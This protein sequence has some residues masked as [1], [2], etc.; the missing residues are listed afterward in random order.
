MILPDFTHAEWAL[1]GVASIFCGV[2]KAGLAGL[3]MLN[4]LIMAHL[5]PGQAS[6]GVVLPMLIAADVLAV[7]VFG[8]KHADW[9]AIGRLIVPMLI[10]IVAGWGLMPFIP[11]GAFGSVIGWM[12]LAMVS[13]QLVR[14]VWPHFDQHL[15]HSRLFGWIVGIISGL[16]TMIANAAGP[17]SV[18][19]FLILGFAKR[20]FIAT[21][22]WLFLIINVLK[23]PLSAQ[24]GLI[25]GSSL[26]LNVVLAPFVGAGFFLGRVMTNKLPQRPFER[27]VLLLTII[28]AVRLIVG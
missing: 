2:G 1:A 7:T 25:N 20:E 5:V 26:L 19:Y 18:I 14:Q 3:G 28:S 6:S 21:M 23:V 27:V 12:V 8:G 10:G 16:A 17:I 15:P 22:A 9:R 4:V 13:L 24:Q 11:G